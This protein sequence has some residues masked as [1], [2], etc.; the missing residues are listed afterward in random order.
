MYME[1]VNIWARTVRGMMWL[2]GQLPLG[3]LYGI[4]G[5]TAWFLRNIACYRKSVIDINLARSF[6]DEENEWLA[7]VAKAYYKRLGNII[8]EAVWFGGC[9]GEK[10][11]RR[12]RKKGLCEYSNME[13]LINL[14]KDRGVVVVRA[15][16]GNWELVGGIFE[17]APGINLH[18]YIHFNDIHVANRALNNKT[19]DYVMSENRHAPLPDYTAMVET[20]SL[21]RDM[22]TH[23]A[24]RPVYILISDQSPYRG[25]HPVGLFLNQPT[26]GMLGPFSLASKLG[27]AVLYC[28]D[29]IVSKG[30]YSLSFEV[31]ADD[32]TGLDPEKMMRKYYE[33][34]EADIRKNPVNWLWSH[35]R[36]KR[37]YVGTDLPVQ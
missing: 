23:K 27:F 5:V 32:A 21:L 11:A 19:F 35:K 24:D 17:Y 15:H 12:L 7:S 20:N 28:R 36:W 16:S 6:P 31:I 33:L 2:L 14:H 1:N 9:T 8:A 3:V 26:N 29:E 22:L 34:L 4:G 30:H 25:A 10:G 13:T 18:E 37:P